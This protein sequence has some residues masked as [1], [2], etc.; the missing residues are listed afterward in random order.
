MKF[1]IILKFDL[2]E[3]GY[4]LIVVR[5]HSKPPIFIEYLPINNPASGYF[6]NFVHLFYY[7]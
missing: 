4:K 3:N 5:G 7:S 6:I 2:L 1:E